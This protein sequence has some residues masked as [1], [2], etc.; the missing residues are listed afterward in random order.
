MGTGIAVHASCYRNLHA[1]MGTCIPVW[2]PASQYRYV[3]PNTCIL[4][5][6]SAAQY[7]YLHPGMGNC[8]PV[9]EPASRYGYAHPSTGM[10]S[11][12][13]CLRPGTGTCIPV[14]E[15]APWYRCV[16]PGMV[17]ASQYGSQHPSASTCTPVWVLHPGTGVFILA[18]V[19]TSWH[20][21]PHPSTALCIPLQEPASQYGSQHPSTGPSTPVHVPAPGRC[22]SWQRCPQVFPLSPLGCPQ[23]SPAAAHPAGVLHAPVCRPAEPSSCDPAP[24]ICHIPVWVPTSPL[25]HGMHWDTGTVTGC[26]PAA[27]WGP[28]PFGVTGST[29]C[30]VHLGIASSIPHQLRSIP[31]P[32]PHSLAG[33]RPPAPGPTSALAA[34]KDPTHNRSSV[35][36][37]S[38]GAQGSSPR[39]EVR[40]WGL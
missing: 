1:S 33:L 13:G 20:R 21:Y 25:Q 27:P 22:R 26:G 7:G 9:Q 39:G 30:P 40:L 11:M 4:L 37:S 34:Q 14:W 23:P 29:A 32:A 10:C 16:Q 5:Q 15:P 18:R 6:V 24:F 35:A 36:P 17:S 12:V 8:I 19:P 38:P 2:E 28:G 3:H 31:V